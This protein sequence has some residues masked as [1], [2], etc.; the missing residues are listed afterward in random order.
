MASQL[1]SRRVVAAKIE[2]VEG[3]AE[4]LSAADG[5]ILVIDPTVS[6]DIESLERKPAS[7]SLSSFGNVSGKQSA[8]LSFT[9]EI[10]G[11]GAAY[12]SSVKPALS[13]Y[14]RA[15]GFAETIV[16]TVGVEKATYQPASTGIPSL[17]MACYEDGVIKKLKGCRGTVKFNGESGGVIKAAFE[18]SGVLDGTI[19]GA[20]LT[21]TYEST[22][23]PTLLNTPLTFDAYTAR[24]Q[25]FE[26]NLAAAVSIMED[27]TKAEGYAVGVIIGRNPTGSINPEMVTIA[28]Y[29]YF[30][31]YK[32][33]A[34][35]SLVIGKIG[36]V[37]YNRFKFTAPKMQITAVSD[38]DRN[39]VAVADLSV[40]FAR[41]A[42]DDEIVLEFD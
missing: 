30:G 9:A 19:D 13:Q 8:K 34:F 12:S 7:A 31:K 10:K 25:S 11:A 42:G 41:N 33:A 5:G 24:A 6:V 2:A 3:I 39:G 16:T 20:M 17:T 23:P 27:I 22:I 21:P 29:D 38:G 1:K 14:L 35:I 18:F 32:S 40:L 15:C 37:Q 4:T 28:T 36:S 26:I